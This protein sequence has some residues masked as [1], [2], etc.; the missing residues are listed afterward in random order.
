MYWKSLKEQEYVNYWL[1]IFEI[2]YILMNIRRTH[3]AINASIQ[4]RM[5]LSHATWVSEQQ[6]NIAWRILEVL[7]SRNSRS[8][9]SYYNIKNLS[10]IH[11]IEILYK[12]ENWKLWI[13]PIPE[14]LNLKL[15]EAICLM[16]N[17]TAFTET[18]CM[19]FVKF[20]YGDCGISPGWLPGWELNIIPPEEIQVW[21]IVFMQ[22]YRQWASHHAAIYLGEWLM[23]SKLWLSWIIAFNLPDQL[24]EMYNP[25]KITIYRK[26]NG[27]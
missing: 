17:D 2:Y 16:N 19:G 20:I 7:V 22:A 9:V 11:W 18:D 14:W 23:V 12:N 24:K 10:R 27:L 4:K 1:Y 8:L 3:L 5:E 21:D 25:Q 6:W 15:S 26:S 13:L